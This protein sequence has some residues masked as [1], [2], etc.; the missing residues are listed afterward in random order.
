MRSVSS[1]RPRRGSG[2]HAVGKRRPLDEQRANAGGRQRFYDR[3]NL[4]ASQQLFAGCRS[5][6][7]PPARR[8]RSRGQSPPCAGVPPAGDESAS[9]DPPP[10]RSPAAR[11]QTCPGPAILAGLPATIGAT[12]RSRAGED[13]DFAQYTAA[14]ND[15][16]SGITRHLESRRRACRPRRPLDDERE[17]ASSRKRRRS[18]AHRRRCRFRVPASMGYARRSRRAPAPRSSAWQTRRHAGLRRPSRQPRRAHRRAPCLIDAERR[19]P[20]TRRLRR[21]GR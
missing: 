3:A 8:G 12:W 13:M 9:P 14:K 15:R 6:C 20:G 2:I 19:Q 17:T 1:L 11:R 18:A 16:M 5:R 10:R 21:V 4:R 7:S